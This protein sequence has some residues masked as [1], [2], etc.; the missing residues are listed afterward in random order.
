MVTRKR[1]GQKNIKA[2]GEYPAGFQDML[3]NGGDQCFLYLQVFF[4]IYKSSFGVGHPKFCQMASGFGSFGA[5]NRLKIINAI[6]GRQSC[7][8]I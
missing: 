8:E 1:K 4:M 6:E 3:D 5:K 2:R 7:F